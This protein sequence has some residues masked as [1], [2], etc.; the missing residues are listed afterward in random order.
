MLNKEDKLKLQ[1]LMESNHEFRSIINKIT[2]DHAFTLSKF[3]HEIRNPLTLINSSLQIIETQHPEVVNFKFWKETLDDLKYVRLLLDD[4]SSYNNG[5]HLNV[6]NIN[7]VELIQSICVTIKIET[8]KANK[9]FKQKYERNIPIIT[10]DPVKI[11]QAVMNL[12][13]NA[14]DATDENGYISLTLFCP[15]KKH[16]QIDIADN[17]S[18]IPEEYHQTLFSPFVTHKSNGTGLG[19]AIT[20]RVAEAHNG[21]LTFTTAPKKGT[22]FSL[23][24]PI[25][26]TPDNLNY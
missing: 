24:I 1:E 2:D 25:E 12:L 11:R 14:I 17:G 21:T 15:D 4:L 19:L 23:I 18:G 22:K 20:M 9:R 5:T 26:Y 16:I 7:I 10:G 13:K 3:S 6:T 8:D